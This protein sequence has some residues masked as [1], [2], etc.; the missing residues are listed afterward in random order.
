M[1]RI[2]LWFHPATESRWRWSMTGR[3]FSGVCP[4]RF[5]TAYVFRWISGKKKNCRFWQSRSAAKE[6]KRFSL[7]LRF[8]GRTPVL[9]LFRSAVSPS[10]P[11]ST[12]TTWDRQNFCGRLRVGRH[13]SLLRILSING[14]TALSWNHGDCFPWQARCSCDHRQEILYL[15]DRKGRRLPVVTHCD[16]C[17]NTIWTDRPI[18]LIGQPGGELI[19]SLHGVIF[20]FFLDDENSAAA[21]VKAYQQWQKEGFRPAGKREPE[22][23]WNYGIE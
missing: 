19:R 22:E 16:R 23:H 15:S 3:C 11:V 13:R 2:L 9:L 21:A 5:L 6:R 18:N 7:F 12:P 8:C 17:Y 20:H 14:I 1:F 4:I 10:G